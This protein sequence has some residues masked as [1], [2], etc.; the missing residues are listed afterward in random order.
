MYNYRVVHIIIT[1]Y[2]LDLCTQGPTTISIFAILWSPFT[3]NVTIVFCKY[4]LLI[5]VI[6]FKAIKFKFKIQ[7]Q[8]YK[9]YKDYLLPDKNH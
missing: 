7:I 4:C 2:L 5:L 1:K 9:S 8:S 6:K 3:N